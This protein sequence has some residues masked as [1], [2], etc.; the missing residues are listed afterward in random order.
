MALPA[1]RERKGK[2]KMTTTLFLNTNTYSGEAEYLNFALH[3]PG[4]K[5]EAYSVSTEIGWVS[6]IHI[7][8]EDSEEIALAVL[9][10]IEEIYEDK[11]THPQTIYLGN[12]PESYGAYRWDENMG[13]FVS[14]YWMELYS[15]F[16]VCC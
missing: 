9:N 3:I 16:K 2:S 10:R 7:Y 6:C 5:V 11:P 14:P 8:H 4:A 12:T 1:Q 15:N 13:H